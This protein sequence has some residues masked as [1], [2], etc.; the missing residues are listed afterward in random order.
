MTRQFAR[1]EPLHA[2]FGDAFVIL[3]VTLLS[4][5]S[6]AWLISRLG[7]ELWPAMLAALTIYCVLLLV[8]VIVRR[9]FTADDDEEDDLDESDVHWQSAAERF[10]AALADHGADTASNPAAAA[11]Q[12]PARSAPWDLA[13]A[14]ADARGC[15]RGR[16]ASSRGSRTIQVP[17]LA[18]ALFGDDGDPLAPGD[19][20]APAQRSEVE[21][22]VRGRPRRC[23]SRPK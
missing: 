7:F 9:S 5:A 8:H 10:D 18:H 2:R 4:L 23:R 14:L 12:P 21:L 11:E 22:P 16:R 20:P 13:D 3:S 6:G 19:A 15:G 1:S 17:A